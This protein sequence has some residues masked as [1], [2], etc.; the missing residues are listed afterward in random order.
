MIRG[1]GEVKGQRFVKLLGRWGFFFLLIFAL[2]LPGTAGSFFT[3]MELSLE[4]QIGQ[5]SY[6]SIVAQKKVVILPEDE[7]QRLNDVFNRLVQVCARRN[8]LKF[9]LT[10]VE[11]ETINAFALPAGYI[12]VHTELLAYAVSDGEL[13]GVLAHEIAHVDRKH[14]MDAIKRQLGMALLFRVFFSDV[15][16]ELTKIGALAVNLTQLGYGREAEY[17]ADRYGVIFMEKAGYDRAEILNFWERL[18]QQSGGGEE[19]KLLQLFS[20]HPP[21]V[22]RIKRIKA[23]PTPTQ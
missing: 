19:P 4:K 16:E 2:S 22:E 6:E 1:N 5:N 20:T 12:F 23:L 3:D 21:T 11:D 18:V 7:T 9:S 10:V 8:E 13:A 14:S 15:S 17:E